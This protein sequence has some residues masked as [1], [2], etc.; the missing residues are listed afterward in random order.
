MSDWTGMRIG[1]T[2]IDK[3]GQMHDIIEGEVLDVMDEVMNQ[4]RELSDSEPVQ[5]DSHSEPT[6]TRQEPAENQFRDVTNM[7]PFERP[8]QPTPYSQIDP[9]I[10]AYDIDLFA[11]RKMLLDQTAFNERLNATMQELHDIAERDSR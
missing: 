6:I 7:V 10:V 2:E 3:A 11:R 9:E 8:F 5:G 1:N 4:V